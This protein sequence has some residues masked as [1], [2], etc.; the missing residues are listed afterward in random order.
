MASVYKLGL[1]LLLITFVESIPAL[2]QF[3]QSSA[4][5]V[6]VSSAPSWAH[7]VLLLCVL[8]SFY[9][10]WLVTLPDWSTVWTM[11]IVYGAASAI[12]GFAFAVSLLTPRDQELMLHLDTVRRLTPLWTAAMV[13]LTFLAAFLC[14]RTSTR[15]HRAYVAM[16]QAKGI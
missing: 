12:Y 11:M 3:V 9:I 2:S 5:Y 4:P 14:G 15:W 6:T 16:V 8:Q 7:V 10:V 13:L 1:A